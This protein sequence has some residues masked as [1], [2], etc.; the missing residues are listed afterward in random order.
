[1]WLLRCMVSGDPAACGNVT[2]IETEYGGK[3]QLIY[4]AFHCHAPA[5]MSGELW[6]A[7]TNELICRNTPIYGSGTKPM[8]EASYLMALPPCVWGPGYADPPILTLDMNLT[9]IKRANN[10]NGHWGVMGLWQARSAY[11]T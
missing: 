3:F 10:T 2:K 5:C 7:D 8:D 4:A 9:A 11:L 6:S 1:M